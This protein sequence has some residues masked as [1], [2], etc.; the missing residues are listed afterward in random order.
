MQV[1]YSIT[2]IINFWHWNIKQLNF[3]QFNANSEKKNITVTVIFFPGRLKNFSNKANTI[4][5]ST[6]R[7]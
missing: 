3:I 4:L 7:T 5:F 2:L 1:A 6:S